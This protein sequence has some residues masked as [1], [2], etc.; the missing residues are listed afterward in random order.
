MSTNKD[1]VASNS[2]S[3]GFGFIH[4]FNI[5]IRYL[6]C[7]LMVMVMGASFDKKEFIFLPG[8]VAT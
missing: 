2:Q 6:I 7:K 5:G 3:F 1:K 8:S 4:Q